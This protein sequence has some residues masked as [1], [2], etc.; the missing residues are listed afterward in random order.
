MSQKP[1]CDICNPLHLAE[2]VSEH[3]VPV[4]ISPIN[5]QMG[6]MLFEF[7]LEGRDE[8]PIL[9]VDRALS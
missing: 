9:F 5:G 1:A 7:C 4:T 3:G 8:L 2:R 6:Y